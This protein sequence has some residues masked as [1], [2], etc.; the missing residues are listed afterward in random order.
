MDS[1]YVTFLD[2]LVEAIKDAGSYNS[3]DQVAPAAILWPDAERQWEPVVPLLRDRLPLLA[4][5]VYAPEEGTGPS[6]WLR[7]V[8]ER[9]LPGYPIPT[10]EVPIV[11]LPGISRQNIRAVEEC[12]KELQPIAELQYRGCLFSQKNG[13]DWTITA[14]LQSAT[15]PIGVQVGADQ[16]TKEAILRARHKLPG[17]PLERLRR[18][19]PLRSAFFDELL[20][21]DLAR[22]LLLWLNDP[23]RYRR[24]STDD[25]WASFRGKCQS[26]YQLDPEEVGPI[27]VAEQ[28]G[29]HETDAWDLAWQRFLESPESYPGIPER[30]RAA[31]PTKDLGLFGR[32]E[33]WPQDNE[34]A[35]DALRQS[36]S[37]LEEE[38]PS[39]ARRELKELDVEHGKRRSWV[40][41]RLGQAPLA[42]ALEQLAALAEHTKQPLT[43]SQAADIAAQYAERGWQADDAALRAL[44]EV[45]RPDDVK[46]VKAAIRAVYREWLEQGARALQ[47]A[48]AGK[49]FGSAYPARALEPWSEGTCVL[50]CDG[51]RF[52]LA[53]RLKDK[54]GARGMAVAIGV[55][56]AA[57]PTITETAKPAVSPVADALAG[58]GGLQPIVRERGSAVNS[59]V[60][61][62]QLELAGYQ[63][64]KGEDCGDPNGRAWTE[65]G[66]I[67]EI[68][69]T[70]TAKLPRLVDGEVRAVAERIESLVEWGWTRVVVVTDHGW[71]L[72]P[73]GLP[74]AELPQ[75]LTE[76]EGMRKG[77]CARL[78]DLAQTDMQVVPWYWDSA[79]R[80]AVAPGISCFEAGNEY[81]HGGLSPQECLTPVIE[82][83][84]V[85]TAI[86]GSCSVSVRWRGLWCDFEVTNAPP[87]AMV[88]IRT[89]AGDPRSSIAG[90]RPL[91]E[92]GA[93]SL[94]VE[95]DAMLEHAAFGVVLDVEGQV[96]AQV[97]TTVGGDV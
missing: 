3:A 8:I 7:C 91:N 64:L 40:W 92:V 16:A 73:G 65:L 38:Q 21:P 35:E 44:A 81:E 46:A 58:G 25:E 41:T 79:V 82:V 32:P 90:P 24:T 53:Q 4:L 72:L 97:Q 27:A 89:K 37:E 88:D 13:R 62:R 85:A 76:G 93:A 51:L 11:Y 5:G 45:E 1:Q 18:A 22:N 80:I 48:V 78:K 12:P 34:K 55:R 57:V 43:G 33:S 70:Q 2:A 26:T 10:D 49:D 20:T 83:S 63:V 39:D 96:V 87:S 29:L 75:H 54:L 95:D 71:L 59:E 67:D 19:A 6:Y 86:A 47:Q 52:D 84:K 69:H 61:R 30:L 42:M 50:F 14:F 9:T 68:G 28:L 77:R 15:G 74:K 94:P 17:V 66:D 31:R 56:L 23:A 36:L 60:L